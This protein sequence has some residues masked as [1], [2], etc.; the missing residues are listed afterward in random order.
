MHRKILLTLTCLFFLAIGVRLIYFK[1]Y[2]TFFWD[3]ARDAIM[4]MEIWSGDP[5]K[6]LGPS[7]DF[8]GIH[9]GPLYWYLISPF[10]FL[11]RGNPYAV[12][13][14][15]ILINAL[16]VF[17][18]YKL[19]QDLF[20]KKKVS[21]IAAFIFAVSFEAIQYGR[22][23]SNPSLA[24]ITTLVSFLAL[25]NMLQGKKWGLPLLVF[26][27][28]L[29]VQ[30]QLFMLY[31]SV[32]FV[33]VWVTSKGF[34]IPSGNFKSYLLTFTAFF[35]T[36][37]TYIISEFK[38][39]FQGTKALVNFFESQTHS[40]ITFFVTLKT[41]FARV[42]DS[43]YLNIW[44]ANAELAKLL[45]LFSIIFLGYLLMKNKF[46]KQ[47]KILSIWVFSPILAIFLNGPDTTY[48][49]LGMLIPIIILSALIF[50]E[51]AKKSTL[52]LIALL[53]VVAFGNGS[54]IYH[55][56]LDGEAIFDVQHKSILGDQI[57]AIAWIYKEAEGKPFT[58][59]TVT[60]PLFINTRWA[61][62]F[63]WQAKTKY[64]YMP[65][66]W[67]ETQVDVP[68][69]KI[70]FSEWKETD[71]HF[72]IIEPSSGPTEDFTKVIKILENQRSE[73]IK[74]ENFGV[75]VVEKRKIKKLQ[76][77]TGMDAYDILKVTDLKEL[78][79]VE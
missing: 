17:L 15:L 68:G 47:I 70:K 72:L 39:N 49:T 10:Y 48:I 31:Q 50:N 7:S 46:K 67:G 76:T 19:T 79:K 77:F 62:L 78:R 54:L 4:A 16:G 18:I 57:R 40:G 8:P 42:Y 73:V 36:F 1:D 3:Q 12:R 35:I 74:R 13:L 27:W 25:N 32:I 9:H 63:D 38:F 6:I 21:L 34:R 52:L 5:I 41:Y 53:M 58:I 26:S 30:F 45:T 2:V 69:S 23:L 66:W 14:F 65:F 22:W 44:G 24:L 37:A 71:M 51:I 55:R 20:N 56:R 75:F 60:E 33:V 59:N 28:G 43:F 64:G 29:S 11:T 61:F